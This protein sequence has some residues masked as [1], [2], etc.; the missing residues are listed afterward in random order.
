LARGF[1]SSS[2]VDFVHLK[3]VD[4]VLKVDAS[5]TGANYTKKLPFSP[6]LRSDLRTF[7]AKYLEG[8]K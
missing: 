1:T 3:G 4:H 7:V 8:A 6:K 5:L 2:H